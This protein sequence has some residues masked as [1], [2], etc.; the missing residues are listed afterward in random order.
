MVDFDFLEVL[1][2]LQATILAYG[3]QIV[4]SNTNVLTPHGMFALHE[5]FH[6]VFIIG[7]V[8]QK[9]IANNRNII[10]KQ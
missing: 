9:L 4:G 5:R 10:Y 6:I 3:T 2:T 8:K 7:R 1:D